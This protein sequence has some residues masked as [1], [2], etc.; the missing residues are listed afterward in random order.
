MKQ[1]GQQVYTYLG[2]FELDKIRKTEMKQKVTKECK[3]R[4]RLILKEK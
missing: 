1:L 3:R 4:Q 2:I